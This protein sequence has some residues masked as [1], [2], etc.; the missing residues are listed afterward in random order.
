MFESCGR[1]V[2]NF[3]QRI[4]VLAEGGRRPVLLG[5]CDVGDSIRILNLYLSVFVLGS[6]GH[7]YS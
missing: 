3:K 7:S 1:S 5:P 6:H 4:R 2:M